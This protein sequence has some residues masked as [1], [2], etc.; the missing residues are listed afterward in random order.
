MTDVRAGKI[1]TAKNFVFG[2]DLSSQVDGL[3]TEFTIA[4]TFDS[5]TVAVYLNGLRL[6]RGVGKDYVEGPGNTITFI[7]APDAE[8]I[9]LVDY[10]KI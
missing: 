9:V 8:D 2:E 5:N 10:V 4:E 3:T 1:S 7:I 6:Q